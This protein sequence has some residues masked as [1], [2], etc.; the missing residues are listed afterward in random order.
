MSK[1][2]GWLP[3]ARWKRWLLLL[4]LGG[5]L[6][7]LML[8]SLGV[9]AFLLWRI[10]VVQGWV[11]VQMLKHQV[12]QPAEIPP[13]PALTSAEAVLLST[14]VT[15]LRSPAELFA[16][17]N[18]W[19]VH[20]KFTSNQWAALGP[21]L[22]PPIPGFVQPDGTVILRNP[23]A[24][25]NGLAGVLGMDFPWSQAELQFGDATF[26]N[27][28]ARF[29]GNGTFL[30]S[31]RTYKR[32]FKLDLSKKEKSQQLAGRTTL[33]FHNLTADASCLSD[34]L[35]YEFFRDAGVP[36]P[37][38]AFARL[39][40][41]I[42]GRFEDRLLG[43]Y[44]LVENPDA[45]W[46]RDQ[47]GVDGMALFKPVT[48]E[49]FK[50]LGDNWEAYEG[51]YDPKTKTKPKQRR[52]LLDLT[53]L[54]THASDSTFTEQIGDF[55][56]LDEFA[57]F[58]ACQVLLSNY[59][60]ILSD[61][62][63]FLLYL[64]PQTE[65]FGFIPWDLDHCWG[66]FP[67]LATREERERAS[68]WHPWVGENRFLDRMLATA[69]FRQRYRTELER[70]REKAFVPERLEARLEDLATIVRP[71]IAEES[72]NRLR[73]FE[74]DI[75]GAPD[76]GAADQNARAPRPHAFSHKRFFEARAQSVSDQLAGRSQ[77]V[78]LR[79]QPPR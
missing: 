79:R 19:D 7:V 64:D 20:L 46:A 37:H 8:V 59:D 18:L 15:S 44:V 47:F 38:T 54:V 61:G 16:T 43:L 29:K 66:E 58:L 27:V 33:N 53:K 48:Y 10:P 40:L 22:V 76:V 70:L 42:E 63:N 72:S 13:R 12:R 62:Q 28:G 32:P 25:R 30:D 5:V 45:E 6:S 75:S 71:F 68:L 1:L 11:M 36:A 69:A 4:L 77:G 74:R 34:A 14:N 73:K 35:A 65:R 50:D 24:S 39:R 31:Q 52:R 3:R 78:I 51:I 60:G 23:K 21:N 56:D 41:T 9:T 49:L 2:F 26:A 57:R 17:T 67:F 55:I